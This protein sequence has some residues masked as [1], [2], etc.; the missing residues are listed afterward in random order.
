MNNHFIE[1]KP[2]KI[3]VVSVYIIFNINRQSVEDV[4][5]CKTMVG[6]LRIVRIYDRMIY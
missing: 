6:I 3:P 5:V 1:F 2:F 4:E